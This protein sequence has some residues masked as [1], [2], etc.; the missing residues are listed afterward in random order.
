MTVSAPCARASRVSA[1]MS[2]IFVTGFV[3]LSNITSRV[4]VAASTRSMP[5]RSSIDNIVC[6]TPKRASSLRMMARVGA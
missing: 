1:A 2:A 3:G 4:G 5:A 6:C